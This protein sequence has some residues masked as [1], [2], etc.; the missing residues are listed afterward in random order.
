M[1]KVGIVGGA[2]YTAGEL[3]RLL[4]NH[5]EAQIK[6][7]FSTSQAGKPVYSMH[8]DLLGET[9]L[10]FSDQLEANLDVVFLCLG[11]GNSQAFLHGNDLG[12]AKVIDLSNDFRLS[13]DA[14]FGK[15]EFLY[16]LPELNLEKI[17]TAEAIANPGCFATATQ[18]ALLPLASGN[19]L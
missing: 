19:H 9:D 16:G 3:I 4:I 14:H 17:K 18:L 13:K 1:I 2:G 11:H 12:S 7:I 5:P 10:A 8:Q 6:S 15:R